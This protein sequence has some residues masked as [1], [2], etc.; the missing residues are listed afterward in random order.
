[1]SKR[2]SESKLENP[3]KRGKAGE[4][5]KR[6][7]LA[8]SGGLDTSVILC[9]L[10]EQGYQ[11]VCYCANVGQV[12][13]DLDKIKAK[14]L[15][16]GAEKVYLEDLREEFVEDFIYPFLRSGTMYEGQYL[17]GTSIAR[18][19][20]AKRQVEIAHKENC[21]YLAHGATG[22]GNDQVRFE[23]SAN[24]LDPSL[25]T[26]A[27]WRMPVFYEKFA[28]RKDL[29]DYA[30]KHGVEVDQT[31]KA[32]YSIDEN[33]FHTSY[34]SGILED[35]AVEPPKDM[36]KGTKDVVVDAKDT[37][38]DVRIE[39]VEGN[40]IRITNK[41]DGTVKE[42]PFELFTYAN[43]LG[44]AHG[45]GRIDMVENRFI[46]IKSRGVYETPGGT[47]LYQ[48]HQDLESVSV[49]KG[50]LRARDS[51]KPRYA[52]LVY[53]GFWYSPEME[54]VVNAMEHSQKLVT[55]HVDLTLYKGNVIVRGRTATNGLYN[56]SLSS[57]ESSV[58]S[59]ATEAG[60]NNLLFRPEHSTGFIQ[61]N[62]LRLK[63]HQMR[64][65]G[66]KEKNPKLF[67]SIA[68]HY[69]KNLE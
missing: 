15:K 7:V 13:D 37:P 65:L 36:F 5:N 10:I 2:E 66:I 50:V 49:D 44:G 25:E 27:P 11:V 53:N 33:L 35:P 42:K 34:E 21:K 23:L 48:A 38:D 62:G 19:V 1:M 61:I 20:I 31:P 6:V 26:I 56:E 43:Q 18:P 51:L 28:G 17:L 40:P 55:G 64:M 12:H 4:E 68:T 9:W 69:P 52:E 60:S 22:K 47:I 45:I 39:Y 67:E 8:Y 54:F 14:A 57:M 59:V 46:G 16:C 24:A 63:A 32:S 58:E 29:L 3:A 41:T 30:A